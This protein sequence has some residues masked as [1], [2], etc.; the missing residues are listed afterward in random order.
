MVLRNDSCFTVESRK[1]RHH[2]TDVAV[3]FLCGKR[4]TLQRLF[5][6]IRSFLVA[7]DVIRK[8]RDPYVRDAAAVFEEEQKTPASRI[9]LH[10]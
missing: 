9:S 10:L 3:S 6:S 1:E 8:S 7:P 2:M 4:F 5:K